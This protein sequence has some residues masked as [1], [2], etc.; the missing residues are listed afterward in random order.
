MHPPLRT[1]KRSPEFARHHKHHRC[2]KRHTQ[3]SFTRARARALPDCPICFCCFLR[4]MSDDDAAC[5]MGHA[6]TAGDTQ[7]VPRTSQA[8]HKLHLPQN[9][10][11]H[12]IHTH[13]WHEETTHLFRS[14]SM[15]R[16]D[17][18]HSLEHAFKS[19]L[20]GSQDLK[21]NLCGLQQDIRSDGVK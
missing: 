5:P 13:V 6:S 2:C 4:A 1:S 18:A 12:R 16:N 10:V 9:L 21:V 19:F 8:L 3:C 17:N 14:L 20:L 11:C 15:S 7:A